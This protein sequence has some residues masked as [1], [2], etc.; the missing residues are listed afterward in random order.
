MN[1]AAGTVQRLKGLAKQ[2]GTQKRNYVD[3]HIRKIWHKIEESATAKTMATQ[4][5]AQSTITASLITDEVISHITNTK[6]PINVSVP[7][8]DAQDVLHNVESTSPPLASA[9]PHSTTQEE[10]QSAHAASTILS[11]L[12]R[13]VE[14]LG[15]NVAEATISAT[16][17]NSEILTGSV[18]DTSVGGASPSPSPNTSGGVIGVGA[19]SPSP[20]D[21]TLAAEDD[22]DDF[23]RDIGWDA[24]S[25]SSPSPTPTQ[26]SEVD[27]AA[28][29]ASAQEAEAS[30]LASI[31]SKRLAITTRHAALETDLQS[32]I[33]TSTSQIINILNEIRE[34]KKEELISMIEGTSEGEAGFVAELT[35]IG[36]KLMKG[37]DIYLKKCQERSG[38]W[39]QSGVVGSDNKREDGEDI[40]KHTRIAE[41]EQARLESVIEKVEIKF[42]DGVQ[43]LQEQVHE[44]YL[45]MILKEQEEVGVAFVLMN[46]N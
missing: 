1:A 17:G 29:S 42:S 36:D 30:R 3:P 26:P 40:Q 7:E 5:V 44:W 15:G 9:P 8:E 32:S 2:L 18:L 46:G 13:E 14:I 25:S 24:S 20:S 21:S 28:A 4:E 45:D 16:V 43:R 35:L 34:A 11:E 33:L 10:A 23:L 38:A 39:K 37:L 19:S 31:A 6:E 41:D 27:E 22:L 12:E